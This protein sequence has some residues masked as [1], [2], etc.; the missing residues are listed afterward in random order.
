[1][2]VREW[3][4]NTLVDC[5]EAQ[6]NVNYISLIP[7]RSNYNQ[8][9]ARRNCLCRPSLHSINILRRKKSKSVARVDRFQKWPRW[10]DASAKKVAMTK[11]GREKFQRQ[12][13]LSQHPY[14]M[15]ENEWC[16]VFMRSVSKSWILLSRKIL[17]CSW[18]Q[19]T[20]K[21]EMTYARSL[22]KYERYYFSYGKLK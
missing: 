11:N 5:K 16:C 22:F 12:S 15:V 3:I 20:T 14:A 6:S 2:S 17:L 4:R 8:C 18:D 13:P 19:C 10:Q 7:D 21:V 9:N 1:M